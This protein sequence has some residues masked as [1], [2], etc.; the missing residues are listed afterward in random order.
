[1]DSQGK[2]EVQDQ[3]AEACTSRVWHQVD[4]EYVGEYQT[5]F[6]D[7]QLDRLIFHAG[8]CSSATVW[9][10]AWQI[11]VWAACWDDAD[12]VEFGLEDTVR[13]G[14][15]VGVKVAVLWMHQLLSVLLSFC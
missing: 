2:Q 10:F 8:L 5:G 6:V 11:K 15:G 12:F 3:D 1:M 13:F 7:G 9:E 14:L 4:D